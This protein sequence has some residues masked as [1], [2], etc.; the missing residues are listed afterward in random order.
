[1]EETEKIRESLGLPSSPFPDWEKY[2]PLTHSIGKYLNV[3]MDD[4]AEYSQLKNRIS[5]IRDW[6]KQNANSEDNTDVL[7]AVRTLEN[8]LGTPPAGEKRINHL[9]KWIR[10]DQDRQRIEKE[11]KI[12]EKSLEGE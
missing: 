10:L 2:D 1:M 9:Y 7:W 4:I 6:A 12:L 5:L 8:R 3:K 11:Q